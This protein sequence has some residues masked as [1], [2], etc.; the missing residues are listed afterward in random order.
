MIKVLTDVFDLD[1][2]MYEED[3]ERIRFE[4][5]DEPEDLRSYVNLIESSGL[6][7]VLGLE[8]ESQSFIL[9]N[10]AEL[11]LVK[12][13]GGNL[14]PGLEKLPH[15]FSLTWVRVYLEKQH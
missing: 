14:R 8:Q 5:I 3:I 2:I 10:R 11:I 6:S 13:N 7:D 15:G 1:F 12:V 9:D 4:V